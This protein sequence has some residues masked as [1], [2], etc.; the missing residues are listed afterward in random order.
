MTKAPTKHIKSMVVDNHVILDIVGPDQHFWSPQLNFRVEPLEDDPAAT[1]I[2]GIIGP[3]PTVWTM[4]MFIYF[5]V[6]FAGFVTFSYGVSLRMMG[7]S[8]IYLWSLPL[9]ILFMLTAY[10]AGKIGEK[11]GED[12]IELLKNFIREGIK[13]EHYTPY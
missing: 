11:L 4:F 8:S 5:S 12:Q 6:G 3:R 2:A 7:E 1:I 10:R 13:S 9:A